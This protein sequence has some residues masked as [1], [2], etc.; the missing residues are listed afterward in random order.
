ML[1]QRH[2]SASIS[3][4]R[5]CPVRPLV[6]EEGR[7]RVAPGP[8][9]DCPEDRVHFGL[10]A[11]S[12]THQRRITA[13]VAHRDDQ[14][15]AVLR[16]ASSSRSEPGPTFE[17]SPSAREIME[18]IDDEVVLVRRSSQ[19]HRSRGGARPLRVAA[20]G[21]RRACVRQLVGDGGLRGGRGVPSTIGGPGVR[22]RRR[23]RP[24]ARLK[25][26]LFRNIDAEHLYEFRGLRAAAHLFRNER[27]RQP[28]AGRPRS[29]ARSSGPSMNGRG[30]YS[31][32][33]RR[34]SH[35]GLR[36]SGARSR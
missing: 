8:P 3:S 1:A 28:R 16:H 13:H 26:A 32:A 30:P 34:R 24:I 27:A 15:A 23:C 4:R 31:A 20:R 10:I 19:P 18:T 35:P 6:M 11:F 21:R 9:F 29:S 2:A 7:P 36:R 14:A 17:A 33:G 25:A 5:E 12:R 22:R